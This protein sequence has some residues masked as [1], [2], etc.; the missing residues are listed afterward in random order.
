MT[1]IT[2]KYFELLLST[3][4]MLHAFFF[5]NQTYQP[6]SMQQK[7]E[8]NAVFLIE[9]SQVAQRYFLNLSKLLQFM[10]IVSQIN[11]KQCI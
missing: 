4:K 2:S 10:E 5:L 7:L 9:I 11:S 3:I 1:E 6:L 8:L